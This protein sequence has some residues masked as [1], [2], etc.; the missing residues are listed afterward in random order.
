MLDSLTL[1][2][3]SASSSAT[4]NWHSDRRNLMRVAK[5]Q[6]ARG[7]DSVFMSDIG[8]EAGMQDAELA[9]HFR[10]KL[11]LLLAIFDEGWATI[12]PRLMEIAGSANNAR[13]GMLSMLTV[14]LHMLEKDK[15]LARLLM[16]EG[17]RID[18]ETGKIRVSAGYRR[19]M[20]LCAELA[21]RG[22]ADG[23]FKTALHPRVIASALVHAME[24][25]LRDRML[26]E[27]E[28]D[29]STFSTGQLIAT[30]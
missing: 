19:F 1:V 21:V 14:A 6:F 11:D 17:H 13:E 9:T 25:L 7:Y 8:R 10:T 28:G 15:D 18:P 29:T 4:R 27:A 5:H 12:N 30:F 2:R 22:Q 24:G 26:A 16:F 23:S 20:S 3:N